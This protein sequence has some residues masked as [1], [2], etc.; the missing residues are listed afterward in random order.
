[1]Q[2]KKKTATRRG[3]HE[4]SIYQRKDGLWVS[5][6]SIGLKPNGKPHRKSFTGKT[7]A[8][9]VAKLIPY[10]N[11]ENGKVIAA[12]EEVRIESH[13][14]FWL[15]NYKITMVAPGT[16]ESC[17][18][19]DE[20]EKLECEFE[21]LRTQLNET[22][23]E[24]EI[25]TSTGEMSPI[26][27]CRYC[28]TKA[29]RKII[30]GECVCTVCGHRYHLDPNISEFTDKQIET[31]IQR[32]Q[33]HS[34][35]DKE[36]E[37]VVAWK[38]LHTAELEEVSPGVH[39][40]LYRMKLDKYTVSRNGVLIIPNKTW[41]L[42]D[43]DKPNITEIAFCQPNTYD[44]EGL[45]QLSRV[46]TLFLSEGIKVT[47]YGGEK[48]FSQIKGLEKIMKWDGDGYVVDDELSP[49]TERIVS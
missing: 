19:S 49:K 28:G 42:K 20:R 34:A 11:K 35:M 4:G 10:M 5:Q 27:P 36:N 9:V 41:D 13:M 23:H 3:N 18:S 39:S 44:K 48:P 32:V 30:G 2:R 16:F 40:G 25:A 38:K 21:K 45:E 6:I 33:Y 22:L 26:L 14:M 24:L 17:I 43:E 47:E 15:M 46:R 7:R 31:D 37:R 29:E 1:M 8:E 12:R